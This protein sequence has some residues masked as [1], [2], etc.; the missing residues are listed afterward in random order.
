M[1]NQFHAGAIT[2]ALCAGAIAGSVSTIAAVTLQDKAAKAGDAAAN[3]ERL[4]GAWSL[5]H[6]TEPA[7]G[8]GAGGGRS[9]QGRR[10]GFG[11][12]PGG[13]YGGGR[14]GGGGGR[15][16]YGG[17]HGGGGG[18]GGANAGGQGGSASQGDQEQRRASLDFMRD[19]MTA[20]PRLT[21]VAHDTSVV[22]TDADG[23]GTSLTMNDK[24]VDDKV[25]NGLVK[26]SRKAKWDGAALVTEVDID[27]G[28]KIQHRYEV[29]A[30]SGALQLTTTVSGMPQQRSGGSGT[31]SFVH[32]YNRG[33]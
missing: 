12:G 1:R 7:P 17:G 3:R 32:V 27:H 31:R 2:I 6:D 10:G 13:G 16:G 23:R 19:E 15:G 22:I 8:S 28:P 18:Y 11:G 9:G 30:E 25:E 14:G 20:S 26:I 5:D 24:K 4:S 21:I 33:D 29:V